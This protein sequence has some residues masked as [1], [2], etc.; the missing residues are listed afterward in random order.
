MIK[1][2]IE[3]KFP[4][5][6][7]LEYGGTIWYKDFLCNISLIQVQTVVQYFNFF[8]GIDV[9]SVLGHPTPKGNEEG[10]LPI[11]E[12]VQKGTIVKLIKDTTYDDICEKYNTLSD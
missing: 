3:R 11:M 6:F 1:K 5:I 10:F 4:L 2:V 8:K 12:K 9:I 7:F